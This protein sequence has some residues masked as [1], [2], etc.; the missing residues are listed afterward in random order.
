MT[1][2]YAPLDPPPSRA[3]RVL[4]FAA[5]FALG[6]VAV[7]GM[8][9]LRAPGGLPVAEPPGYV[10]I[11]DA[12]S[13]GGT[14]SASRTATALGIAEVDGFERGV[15]KAFGRVGDG[16]PRAVVVMVVEQSSPDRARW[17]HDA[18]LY[19]MS[20]RGGTAFATPEGF[21]GYHD[22]PDTS[23][24]HRQSVAFHRGEL[25]HLVTVYTQTRENDVAE[26][27]DLALAQARA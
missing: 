3:P 13:G 27:V 17:L 1:D 10:R 18:A 19:A 9:F 11:S 8:V 5:L 2:P 15:L 21:H 26:V 24:R 16:P 6:F 23:G 22:V 25:F 4:L 14:L 12:E 7:L 20:Q